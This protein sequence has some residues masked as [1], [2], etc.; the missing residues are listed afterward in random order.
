MHPCRRR[1]RPGR[2]KHL[3]EAEQPEAVPPAFGLAR[4]LRRRYRLVPRRRYRHD[5]H[6]PIVLGQAAVHHRHPKNAT[7]GEGSTHGMPV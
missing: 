4:R 2:W 5:R 7:H 3:E 1:P 6:R